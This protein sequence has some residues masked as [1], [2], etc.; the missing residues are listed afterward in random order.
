MASTRT[1]IPK[2]SHAQPHRHH[3]RPLAE[4]I[5]IATRSIHAKLNKLIIAR[6]PLALPPRVTDP[7]VYVS[8]L[9]HI[10]PIYITFEAL[11]RD[12]LDSGPDTNSDGNASDTCDP[13]TWHPDSGETAFPASDA[14][15]PS[16]CSRIQSL[17]QHLF[18]PGLMRSGRLR[19]D[20]ANLTGWSDD[21]V[22]G[23]LKV[24][25]QTGRLDDFV[26][27][28]KRVV[29]RRPHVL[30]AYSY[31][32]FMALFAGGRFIRA[33]L[34]SAGDDFWNH[35]PSPIKPAS[36]SCQPSARPTKRASG[37]TDEEIPKDDYYCHA[38]HTM[39]LRFFHFQT[40]ED[41][42][43]LKREFKR[44]LA[45]L[46]GILT[47]REKHDIIQESVCI[48]ENMTLLVQQLDSVCD[49][50][51]RK[52]SSNTT[53]SLY[54]P[55][56]QFHPFRSR[57]RDSVS[58]AR[59][60]SARSSR[61]SSGGVGRA[62]NYWVNGVHPSLVE[63]E[64]Q[65]NEPSGH[66]DVSEVDGGI[67]LCPASAKFMRFEKALPRPTRLPSKEIETEHDFNACL[68]TASRQLHWERV[69]N[70]LIMVAFGAAV[71][72]AFFSARRGGEI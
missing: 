41:G 4:S 72:G 63:P 67:E 34:E 47:T 12:L 32:L 1:E 53:A 22:E 6:L 15:K 57:L 2:D 55:V 33:T 44:R 40:P 11:W 35:I 18:I 20:I 17:L 19:A 70:W 52:D 50:L 62:W 26:Q 71:F 16:A 60:R 27:H 45:D 3:D 10:T 49:A 28:I 65:V 23:Q 46:G 8:G 13:E 48:F 64:S 21:V 61:L 54:E 42:E 9:L 7:A 30:V 25:G 38:T 31:I 5:A 29:E 24:V 56:D 58:I 36:V 68:K 14:H 59:E 39:P 69:V 37:L 51:G 43:D 66:P